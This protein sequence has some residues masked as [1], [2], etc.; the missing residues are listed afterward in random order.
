MPIAPG[1]VA[2][3]IVGGRPEPYLADALA[4]V[5]D[6]CVHAV[7]NDN[8]SS[9]ET[10]NAAAILGSS[11]AKS[12]RLTHLRTTFVDFST[13]RN[14]CIDATPDALRT[15]WA[16][17]ADADEV[18]GPELAAMARL[19]PRLPADVDTLDGYSKNFI[20]SFSYWNTI[21]R[22]LRFFRLAPG[23]R[24]QGK[25]HERLEPL[26]RR[27]ATPA[28]G[29]HYG[30]V[31]TPT[32][33]VDRERLYKSL[34]QPVT[35]L[36]KASLDDITP[37]LVWGEQLRDA[38]PFHGLH[39]AAAAATIARLRVEWAAV[40]AEVDRV[41]AEQGLADRIRNWFRKSNYDRVLWLR[42]VETRLRWGS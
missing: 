24:W 25:V 37:A 21:H 40:F 11:F 22:R 8:S 13:A 29:A 32:A 36:D 20:G 38:L 6:L 5:S 39:P 3:M 1:V 9:G 33:E 42:A 41:V 30:H 10:A 12:G 17:Y 16:L 14:A 28:V 2:H 15:G 4:S 34:G 26:G 31:C 18:H 19:L 35:L 7:I 27:E 23:R